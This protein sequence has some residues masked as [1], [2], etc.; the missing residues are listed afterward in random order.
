MF[1]LENHEKSKKINNTNISHGIEWKIDRNNKHKAEIWKI[2]CPNP[3]NEH[4]KLPKINNQE[5]V[6]HTG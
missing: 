2:L 4:E 5:R 1:S 3:V 6:G